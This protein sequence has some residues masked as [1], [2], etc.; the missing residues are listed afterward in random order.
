MEVILL[1]YS[2]DIVLKNGVTAT[3][4]VVSRPVLVE[5]ETD[6]DDV[7]IQNESGVNVIGTRN[8]VVKGLRITNAK[9]PR[10]RNGLVRLTVSLN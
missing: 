5:V 6:V 2:A 7:S 4:L 1:N 8:V 9:R 10:E 3:I